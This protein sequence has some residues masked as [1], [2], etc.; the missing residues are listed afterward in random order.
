MSRAW[1]LAMLLPC[2]AG[3]VQTGTG[4]EVPPAVAEV[5]EVILRVPVSPLRV[6][7]EGPGPDSVAL[8]VFC[9]RSDH[10]GGLPVSGTL[11]ILF[12]DGKVAPEDV[13]GK[14]PFHVETFP[15]ALLRGNPNSR[16]REG[17]G[18]FG[19]SYQGM[20]PWGPKPPTGSGITLVARYISPAG[21][22]VLS[23]PTGVTLRPS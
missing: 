6:V 14:K 10:G 20:V 8:E 11:E 5:D 4:R 2:L 9:G 22:P 21:V 12:F 15:N 18:R 3:C 13:M 23:L 16:L 17:V 19:V 1:A 7:G